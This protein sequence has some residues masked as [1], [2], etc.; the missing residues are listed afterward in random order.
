MKIPDGGKII[1]TELGGNRREQP[2][3]FVEEYHT[4]VGNHLYH[5]CEFAEIMQ[6]SGSS[7]EPVQKKE[8]V[9]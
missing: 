6:R 4:E 5:I 8:R 9:R 1:I 2:C 7:Y 3:R